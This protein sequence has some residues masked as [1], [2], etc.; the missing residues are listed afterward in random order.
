MSDLKQPG[1]RA[2]EAWRGPRA[3]IFG[4]WETLLKSEQ[5]AWARVEV[6][7]AEPEQAGKAQ[8][9]ATLLQLLRWASGPNRQVWSGDTDSWYAMDGDLFLSGE[10]PEGLAQ[11]LGISDTLAAPPTKDPTNG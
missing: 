7:P 1:Q 2:Y 3:D 8:E 5:Q 10:T 6:V 4:E 9:A 11:L